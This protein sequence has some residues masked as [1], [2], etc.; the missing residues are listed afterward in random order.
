MRGPR[1]GPH[2]PLPSLAPAFPSGNP[3][4]PRRSKGCRGN[5]LGRRETTPDPAPRRET[6]DPQSQEHRHHGAG[7]RR[8][9]PTARAV[10]RRETG[11]RAQLKYEVRTSLSPILSFAVDGQEASLPSETGA[12]PHPPRPRRATSRRST[13]P[14]SLNFEK[15]TKPQPI[16]RPTHPENSQHPGSLQKILSPVITS[17]TY[18][19]YERKEKKKP[20]PL[21]SAAT[22]LH[23]RGFAAAPLAQP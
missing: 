10:S 23:L 5:T 3:L 16:N 15:K 13:T 9:A 8:H 20:S 12:R 17:D 1:G 4:P 11:S 14:A 2:R 19:R 18:D 22:R 6:G 7:G 21:I